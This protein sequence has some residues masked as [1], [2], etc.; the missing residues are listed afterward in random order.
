MFE[1]K[2][3]CIHNGALKSFHLENRHIRTYSGELFAIGY[4]EWWRIH[5]GP[6]KLC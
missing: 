4:F 3:K 1:T 6:V 2:K 5:I